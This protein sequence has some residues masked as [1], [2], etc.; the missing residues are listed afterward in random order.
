[1]SEAG[2]ERVPGGRPG[3][4]PGLGGGLNQGDLEEGGFWLV[5]LG[6]G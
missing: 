3:R 1:M 4:W 2:V 5:G 6:L